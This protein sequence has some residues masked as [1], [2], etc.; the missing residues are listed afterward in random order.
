MALALLVAWRVEM[1][2]AAPG[3]SL[4][5]VEE[6]VLRTDPAL[7]LVSPRILRRVIKQDRGISS[8]GM[9]VPHY[10]SY[11]I[12]RDALLRIAGRDELGLPAGRELPETVVLLPRPYRA[13]L[14][15]RGPEAI[16]LAAWRFLFHCRVHAAFQA[17]NL[18]QAAVVDRVR[19]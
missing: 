11:V 19:R 3:L 14:R 10:K 13:W 12:G 8:I 17:R 15:S 2:V 18:D 9:Q 1:S 16:L 6:I 5:D 7:V 4:A